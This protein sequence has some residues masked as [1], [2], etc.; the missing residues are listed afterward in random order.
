MQK[1]EIS[2]I[3]F[4][5]SNRETQEMTFVMTPPSQEW[6]VTSEETIECVRNIIIFDGHQRQRDYRLSASFPSFI[7]SS[8]GRA[9]WWKSW[10]ICFS[11]KYERTELYRAKGLKFSNGEEKVF[12]R[13]GGFP[14]LFLF[15]TWY[16]ISFKRCFIVQ[17]ALFKSRSSLKSDCKA[18]RR[19]F[20][21][22][23]F[24]INWR[25]VQVLLFEFNRRSVTERMR[26]FS[27]V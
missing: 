24:C 20:R 12:N 8:D 7:G 21:H 23:L 6:R 15:Y 4:Q 19:L 10:S 26:H 25:C 16:S 1:Y 2:T 13:S 17:C 27:I 9:H 11:Y 3:H 18:F 22:I 14:F 5:L